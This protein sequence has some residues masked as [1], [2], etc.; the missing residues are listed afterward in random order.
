MKKKSLSLL[1]SVC[2][3]TMVSGCNDSD[4]NNNTD[5]NQVTNGSSAEES[6][7]DIQV[8]LEDVSQMESFQ[9]EYADNDEAD[10]SDI[11][12]GKISLQN[13][14]VNV[15][16]AGVTVDG[17]VVTITTAG[18]YEVSG[19]LDNG[20]IIIDAGEKDDVRLVFDGV[21]ITCSDDAAINEVCADKVIITLADGSENTITDGETH[22]DEEIS[23]ALYC[24]DSLTINGKGVLTV[25]GNFNDGITTKDKL[26]IIDADVF[27]EAADDGL[28]GK[29][30]V[31]LKNAVV[32]VT[33]D[34]DGIKS[35]TADDINKGIISVENSIVYVDSLC[36]ALTADNF[37][38][39]ESGEFSLIT[40]GSSEIDSIS[41]NEVNTVMAA[42]PGD[43]QTAQRQHPGGERPGGD[44]PG[45]MKPGDHDEGSWGHWGEENGQNTQ[46]DT[47]SAKALKATNGIYIMDGQFNID[48][49][50]DA[51]HANDMVYILGGTFNISSGDDGIHADNR[52]DIS[53]GTIEI[54]KSY[55]GL[56]A[57]D[58]Y[59]SGG[60]INLIA[61]DDGMN[62][63][64]GNDGS[65]MNGRPGQ[66]GFG[67]NSDASIN[68]SGGD[69]EVVAS[70]DG[71]DSNGSIYFTDGKLIVSGPENG[72]NGILD[73][74]GEFKFDGGTLLASGASGMFQ[75]I[76]SSS[77]MKVINAAGSNFPAGTEIA[78]YDGEKEI[79]KYTGQHS[80]SA[81][82]VVTSEL[83]TGKDYTI[84]I[85]DMEATVQATEPVDYMGM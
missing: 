35:S 3:M 78:V 33:A 70:G 45:G 43:V 46:N 60:T 24:K 51:I 62:A 17:T 23:A 38:K 9:V 59:I 5:K 84:K 28:V 13:T 47:P 26:K 20:K 76:S 57:V 6:E 22:V 55:E 63:A 44:M 83:V 65:S 48:S 4:T 49:S 75:S 61:S 69:I 82:I 2:M 31:A 7:T 67:E 41:A 11:V 58:I 53:G 85:G 54:T 64:G 30:L 19:T 15:E 10:Y 52:L 16:G 81:I 42:Q 14:S 29:D 18:C 66:N 34:G 72:G 79:A 37:I 12:K 77:S 71:I 25:K 68:I 50:D 8:T 56:E 36:D 73:F 74:G 32:D 80:F 1:L 21:S 39:I 40:G 27:V